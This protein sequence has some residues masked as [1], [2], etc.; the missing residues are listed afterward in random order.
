MVNGSGGRDP[1]G[2][3]RSEAHQGSCTVR[4]LT[5]GIFNPRSPQTGNDDVSHLKES[6]YRLKE[7]NSQAEKTVLEAERFRK[8]AE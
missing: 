8:W 1:Q 3:A 7:V 4:Q 6:T 5:S 2:Q